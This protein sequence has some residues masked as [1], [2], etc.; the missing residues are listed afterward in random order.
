LKKIAVGGHDGIAML[1]GK[2]ADDF[3]AH[4]AIEAELPN[5]CALE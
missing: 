4:G 5:M 1:L 3:A 2:V